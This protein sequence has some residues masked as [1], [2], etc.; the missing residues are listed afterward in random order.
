MERLANPVTDIGFVPMK[1]DSYYIAFI[2]DILY[3]EVK[4]RG[5]GAY[6]S[7]QCIPNQ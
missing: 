4:A 7:I 2:F 5:R 1:Y 6:A 3:D